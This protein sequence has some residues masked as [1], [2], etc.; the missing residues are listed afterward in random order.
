MVSGGRWVW[1]QSRQSAVRARRMALA[2]IAADLWISMTDEYTVYGLVM[3]SSLRLAVD[4][5]WP[6]LRLPLRRGCA[7]S[8]NAAGYRFLRDSSSSRVRGQSERKRRDRARSARSLPAVWH[9]GQ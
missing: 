4:R 3:G 6:V 1:D 7:A 5:A 2:R 8:P 9:W